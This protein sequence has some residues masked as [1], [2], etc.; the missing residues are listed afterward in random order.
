MR[1]LILSE[2][3]QNNYR[4]HNLYLNWCSKLILFDL[5]P[6]LDCTQ[7]NCTVVGQTAPSSLK[8]YITSYVCLWAEHT[9]PVLRARPLR[10]IL[11]LNSEQ[12]R[13][14]TAE[15][16][17]WTLLLLVLNISGFDKV[18]HFDTFIVVE[19]LITG[20]S[21]CFDSYWSKGL[22]VYH[23]VTFTQIWY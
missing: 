22:L 20:L 18:L 8:V 4:H 23:L 10:W 19:Y 2:S 21:I 6:Q 11:L 9:L 12:Q 17:Y 5:K 16:C 7:A 15:H 14:V 3:V 1:R 13:A